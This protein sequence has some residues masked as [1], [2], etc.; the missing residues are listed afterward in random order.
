[1]TETSFKL[2]PSDVISLRLYGAI[3][4]N[5]PEKTTQLEQKYWNSN[6]GNI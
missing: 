1:M 5:K 2:H 4:A 6:L 3:K